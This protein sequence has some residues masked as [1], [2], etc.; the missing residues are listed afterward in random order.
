MRAAR[1]LS[2]MDYGGASSNN[3]TGGR[4]PLVRLREVSRPCSRSAWASFPPYEIKQ[5]FVP[6]RFGQESDHSGVSG[7]LSRPSVTVGRDENGWESGSV[8]DQLLLQVESAHPSFAQLDVQ[9]QAGGAASR[10]RCE[11]LAGRRKRLDSIPRQPNQATEGP[12]DGEIIIDNGDHEW[13]ARY[14]DHVLRSA[15]SGDG[16]DSLSDL[17]P[18]PDPP[19]AEGLCDAS[20]VTLGADTP[21]W[22][23]P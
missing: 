4:V 9:D 20:V 14:R 5:R 22:S 10:G 3:V 11:E 6:E 13:G 1:H 16:N 8:G 17:G 18:I 12:A 15:L 7:A 19:A 2:A 23:R 21:P